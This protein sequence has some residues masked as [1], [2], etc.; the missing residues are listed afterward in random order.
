LK[1]LDFKV[2]KFHG[3]KFSRNQGFRVLWFLQIKVSGKFR[4]FRVI[5]NQ[6]FEVSRN[7]GQGFSSYPRN[8]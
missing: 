1:L 2:K 5:R 8:Y 6:G 3:L 7:L 4:G